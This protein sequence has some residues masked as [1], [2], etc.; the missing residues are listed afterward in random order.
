MI[1]K[2][3]GIFVIIAGLMVVIPVLA[4][5]TNINDSPSLTTSSAV[6]ATTSEK[7]ACVKTA[8]AAREASLATAMTAYNNAVSAAYSTRANELSGAYSNTTIK[9]LRTGVKT[10]WNDFRKSIK[11]ANKTWTANRNTAWF[12]FKTAVKVCKAPSSI[13]D[14]GNSGFEVKGQ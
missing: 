9:T 4:E 3:V 12:T 8:V 7:I 6:T 13:S 5:D 10:S 1:K 2:I 11:S 14:S